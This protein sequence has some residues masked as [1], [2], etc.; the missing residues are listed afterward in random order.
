MIADYLGQ[1]VWVKRRT[2]V[3]GYGQPT[4]ATAVQTKGR[5][6]EKQRLV[7]NA[8]GEQITSAVTVTLQPGETVAAGD[9]LSADGTIYENVISLAVSRGLGGAA[10][11]KRAFL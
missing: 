9:Q 6:L 8:Q 10:I 11:L 1:T 2:G 7:R 5:W 4:F 3:D